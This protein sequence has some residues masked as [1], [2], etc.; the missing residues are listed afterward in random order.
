MPHTWHDVIIYCLFPFGILF[1]STCHIRGMTLVLGL[2]SASSSISIHMPHTWHDNNSVHLIHPPFVFQS[3]CHIRGMTYALLLLH[4][5]PWISIHMPHTWHDIHE[6]N[7]L[8]LYL[9]FNPHATYVAWHLTQN[10][11][12]TI[13]NFNP[14]A[15]YVAWPSI[16]PLLDLLKIFQST[17]HIRGMTGNTAGS[18][19]KKY[20]SIHMPHTWHDPRVPWGCPARSYFNPHATYVAWPLSRSIW[21]SIARISI[22]MPHTWHDPSHTVTAV[23]LIISIHM[24]H[25]WHDFR[26][27]RNDGKNMHF[28]PHAT[29]VAWPKLAPLI[30][31]DYKFQSTCHIRGMTKAYSDKH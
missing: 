23:P 20:I 4:V 2:Q 5:Q 6:W 15:T 25:T 14:H 3:T 29:Y 13:H 9:N 30:S 22:H 27:V 12:T 31:T 11:N 24:P 19:Q 17:C 28:N 18:A 1:Q 8:W 21:Q 26:N 16:K 7:L 10:H